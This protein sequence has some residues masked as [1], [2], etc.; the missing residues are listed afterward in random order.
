MGCKRAGANPKTGRS[1]PARSPASEGPASSPSEN[2][3]RKRNPGDTPTVFST[4]LCAGFSA[5][6]TRPNAEARGWAAKQT[7]SPSM[8]TVGSVDALSSSTGKMLVVGLHVVYTVSSEVRALETRKEKLQERK[9]AG[10]VAR[11]LVEGGLL[12]EY[13]FV[14]RE[15]VVENKGVVK[16]TRRWGLR[17]FD[18]RTEGL[19]RARRPGQREHEA[20]RGWDRRKSRRQ[21][22]RSQ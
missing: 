16:P 2:V 4:V 11:A 18:A 20:A 9:V 17:G 7:T 5:A 12:K 3:W 10:A 19:R 13:S 6:L 8:T 21:C 14:G 22:Y 15:G 1:K